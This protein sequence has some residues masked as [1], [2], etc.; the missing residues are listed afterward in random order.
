[1]IP[2]R[3]HQRQKRKFRLRNRRFN[4]RDIRIQLKRRRRNGR[5]IKKMNPFRTPQVRMIRR[6][7]CQRQHHIRSHR[8]SRKMKQNLIHH[9]PVRILF[10][11]GMLRRKSQSLRKMMSNT[12]IQGSDDNQPYDSEFVQFEGAYFVNLGHNSAACSRFQVL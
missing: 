12:S 10:L 6:F 3:N 11:I 8:R 2:I 4:C 1:M 9:N 7:L 5:R